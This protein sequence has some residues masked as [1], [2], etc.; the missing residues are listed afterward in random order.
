MKLWKGREFNFTNYEFSCLRI[1]LSNRPKSTAFHLFFV[2]NS[3]SS[4]Q[5][6]SISIVTVHL[7]ASFHSVQNLRRKF[8]APIVWIALRNW[9]Q[10]RPNSTVYEAPRTRTT[11]WR[12]ELAGIARRNLTPPSITLALA[13]FTL[14]ILEVMP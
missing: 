4:E 11:N 12:L 2:T 9:S 14:L 1:L 10:I 5:W 3:T 6:R 8:F 13:D 7:L